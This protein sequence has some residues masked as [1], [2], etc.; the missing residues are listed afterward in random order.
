MELTA[1]LLMT[2]VASATAIG[3]MFADFNQTHATNP[4]WTP[5][6]RFHVVW[7]VLCQA[8]VAGFILWIV[9]VAEFEGHLLLA[10]LMNFNW[11][12]T[13]FLTLFNMKRFQGSLADVNG[14]PPF[15]FN[16]GGQIRKVDT[17][18]FGATILMLL[19]T[20]ATALL[21]LRA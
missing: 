21:V 13:F 7:Q 12:L 8:G 1:T 18:L 2:L 19:N 11:G 3:P 4:L 16:I 6:A 15:R 17:N 14:I 20:I 9:W 10:A 5:H